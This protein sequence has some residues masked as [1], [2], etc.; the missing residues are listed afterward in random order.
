MKDGFDLRTASKVLRQVARSMGVG[1]GR[2]KPVGQY[3]P[4][5]TPA[6]AVVAVVWNTRRRVEITAGDLRRG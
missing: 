4:E 5:T 2:W 6:G 3:D 1:S